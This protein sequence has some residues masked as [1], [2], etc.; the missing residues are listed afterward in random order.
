MDS[1]L[2]EV[3]DLWKSYGGIYAVRG[4]SLRVE[5]GE[6]HGLLGPNG[7]GKT[8][9]F[10]CLVGLLKPDRGTIKIA[11]H[12]VLKNHDYKRFIGYL[13]ENPSLPDYLTVKEFLFFAGKL[14]GLAGGLL[15]KNV[16]ELAESYDLEK[17]SDRLIFELSKGIR[18]RVATA[19][20][21]LGEPLVLVF[22]EP[23]NG[24]D[25]EAQKTTKDYMAETVR[26]GGSV[27]ISTHILDSA[28]K[29]CDTTTI[30][31]EGTT[32]YSGSIQHLKKSTEL[33]DNNA[34]LEEIFLKL[35]SKRLSKHT[36]N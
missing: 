3:R 32:V 2:V 11:G 35:V 13:P 22:D 36:S 26:N 5:P 9:T 6:V 29:I 27:L 4:V 8:T 34:S 33:F 7:S 15:Q 18:Q 25:P 10:K 20:S 1:H 16:S 14:K 21:L 30:I 28:E 31:V 17:F 12:D 24:L 23:F 19:A